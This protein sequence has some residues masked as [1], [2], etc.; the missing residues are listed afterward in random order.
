MQKTNYNLV[1]DR[2]DSHV[3]YEFEKTSLYILMLNFFLENFFRKQTNQDNLLERMD[4]GSVGCDPFPSP[5]LENFPTALFVKFCEEKSGVVPLD[6][7]TACAWFM[8]EAKEVHGAEMLKSVPPEE[9]HRMQRGPN[10]VG[11]FYSADLI[12]KSLAAAGFRIDQFSSFFDYG[13]S[14]G[15]LLR[16]LAWCYPTVRFAGSDPVK[17]SINWASSN[18]KADNLQFLHQKQVPPITGARDE[19]FDAVSAVSIYSHHG[20]NSFSRWV[21]EMARII[22]QGGVFV[23]TTHGP[24]SIKFY[25]DLNVKPAIRYQKLAEY[26]AKK[27]FSFEEVWL[28]VDD[29]GNKATEAEWGNSYYTFDRVKQLIGDYFEII[30]YG[31]R[32]NQGNQDL[33]VAMRR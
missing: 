26:I 31:R 5:D 8:H 12:V 3:L 17:A 2:V 24:G 32:I 1:R 23:F 10:W 9:I 4:F 15:S 28:G 14:S 33:Y 25:A 6:L 27:G 30:Y 21:E 16:L 22:R 11:D 18:L 7:D 13:C 29:V 19:E 20:I